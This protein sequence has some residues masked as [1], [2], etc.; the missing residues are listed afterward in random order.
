[1]DPEA[2]RAA[3]HKLIDWIAEYLADP[4][5]YP[6]LARVSPGDIR[7]ALPEAAPES[8]EPFEAMLADFERHP[9]ARHHPLEPPRLLRVLRDHG[10][11]AP[12]CWPTCC[13][14]R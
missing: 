10:Q 1:M 14:P 8:G 2:F 4:G 13:R 3:G 5:R 7:G 11:R 9:A 12:A 6:V